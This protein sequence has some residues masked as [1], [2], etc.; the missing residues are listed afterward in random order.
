MN[1]LENFPLLRSFPLF[2]STLLRGSTVFVFLGNGRFNETGCEKKF[3]NILNKKFIRVNNLII[4]KKYTALPRLVC[5]RAIKLISFSFERAYYPRGRNI[6]LFTSWPQSEIY[7]V[8]F[9]DFWHFWEEKPWFEIAVTL[10][11]YVYFTY[12]R[13]LKS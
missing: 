9:W 6:Q 5:M 12:P 7:F 3:G 13:A 4:F 11:I 1:S 2:C 8:I 10:K